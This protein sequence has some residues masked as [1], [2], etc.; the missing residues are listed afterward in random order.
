MGHAQSGKP[1][2]HPQLPSARSW[3][4]R[5]PPDGGTAISIKEQS[6][7]P[8]LAALDSFRTPDGVWSCLIFVMSCP[9]IAPRTF[10]WNPQERCRPG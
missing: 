6:S 2:R 10:F 1:A 4:R 9:S 3:P 8:R 5:A 7:A